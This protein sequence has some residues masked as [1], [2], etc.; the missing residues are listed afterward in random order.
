[1][2]EVNPDLVA[3]K[4]AVRHLTARIAQEAQAT[5]HWA[6]LARN[7]G[8]AE[9][10]VRLEMV[11][12]SLEEALANAKAIP[13]LLFDAQENATAEAHSHD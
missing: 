12:S 11:A 3:I 6:A 9:V 8:V 10:G 13:P 2:H 4:T 1:M 5:N 7:R